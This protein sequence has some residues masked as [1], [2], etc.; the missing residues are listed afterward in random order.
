MLH[1]PA[2]KFFAKCLNYLETGLNATGIKNVGP[3]G[4]T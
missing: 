2:K 3:H 1:I 4:S